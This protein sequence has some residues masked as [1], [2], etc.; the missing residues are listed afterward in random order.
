[1]ESILNKFNLKDVTHKDLDELSLFM[2]SCNNSSDCK[3]LIDR[4]TR[5]FEMVRRHIDGIHNLNSN[6]TYEE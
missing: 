5:L 3:E 2:S 6:G 4:Y 1:M